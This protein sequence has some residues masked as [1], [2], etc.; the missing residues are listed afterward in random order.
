MRGMEVILEKRFQRKLQDAI[1]QKGI[2]QRELARRM[3]ISSQLV[4]DYYH[5]RK[6]PGLDMIERFAQALE[7]DPLNLLDEAGIEFLQPI[8]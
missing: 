4:G 1:E 6:S 2:S 7:V 3:G 5:A 8:G